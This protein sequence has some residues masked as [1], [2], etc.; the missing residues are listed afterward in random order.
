[1][2]W[3]KVAKLADFSAK[4][5][6]V[7]DY[8]DVPVAIYKLSDGFFAIAD[9]CSHAEASLAEGESDDHTVACLLHG[10]KFAIRSGENLSLPAV[11]PVEKYALKIENEE[12]FIDYEE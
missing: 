4:S 12:I 8:D 3:E 2:A 10:A 9:T 5:V 1:M 7:V 11:V 6:I